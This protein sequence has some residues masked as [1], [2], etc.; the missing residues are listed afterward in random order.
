MHGGPIAVGLVEAFLQGHAVPHAGNVAVAGTA[1]D[2]NENIAVLAEVPQDL[3]VFIAGHAALD[4]ADGALA[5]EFLN[6]VDRG[7]VEID[8]FDQLQNPVVDIQQ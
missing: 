2:G 1:A 7:F 6:I 3:D 8:Q 4:E 5:G